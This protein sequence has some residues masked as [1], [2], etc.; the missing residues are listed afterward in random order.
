MLIL[1][2]E[3]DEFLPIYKVDED[4]HSWTYL[5]FAPVVLAAT[6]ALTAAQNMLAATTQYQ[7]DQ[8]EQATGLYNISVDE[9]YWQL[10]DRAFH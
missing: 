4:S 10:N 2:H 9:N 6:M 7:Y 8:Q 3:A 5:N 1:F